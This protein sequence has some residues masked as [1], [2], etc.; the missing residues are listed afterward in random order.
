MS[1]R[2][3]CLLCCQLMYFWF[4][5]NFKVIARQQWSHISRRN[6]VL[7]ISIAAEVSVSF[8]MCER[9][10]TIS[11]A[12]CEF[13]NAVSFFSLDS[14]SMSVYYLIGETLV[15]LLNTSLYANIS[16]FQIGRMQ[17]RSFRD[18]SGGWFCF[19]SLKVQC[20]WSDS[21]ATDIFLTLPPKS[22]K[23]MHNPVTHCRARK[24][25]HEDIRV[26]FLL[27]I[28]GQTVTTSPSEAR[29]GSA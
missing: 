14:T 1:W 26:T 7:N 18:P 23:K 28:L 24:L 22:Q 5:K 9:H 10:S 3:L 11:R 16:I 27:D 20:R 2:V 25:P 13:P 4:Y 19:F 8:F 29:L 17:T 6:L 15:Y 12:I 21:H